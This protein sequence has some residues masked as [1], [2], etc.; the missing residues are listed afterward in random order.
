MRKSDEPDE[1]W[2]ADPPFVGTQ[3]YGLWR[4]PSKCESHSD[5][6]TALG[7]HFAMSLTAA[8]P[9]TLFSTVYVLWLL[10]SPDI[11][12][13]WMIIRRWWSSMFI[14][15]SAGS[16]RSGSGANVCY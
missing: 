1:P 2:V 12:S 6:R 10:I 15:G 13:I 9:F 11:C 7:G 14:V 4:C 3:V 5:R 8:S 16:H